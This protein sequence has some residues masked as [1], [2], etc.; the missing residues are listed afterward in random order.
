MNPQKIVQILKSND[1]FSSLGESHLATIV[2]KSIVEEHA[3]NIKLFSQGDEG[4]FAYLVLN[5]SVAVNVN[6]QDSVITVAIVTEGNLVGEIA[7][8]SS[9]PR[10]ASISTVT[11]TRL[12]RIEQATIRD[13]LD[14]SPDAAMSI[15]AELGIRIQCVNGAIATLTQAATALAADEFKP[16]MLDQLKAEA[17]RFSQFAEVFEHMAHEL[18]SK[19]QLQQEMQAATEIQRSFLPTG[20]SA[21]DHAT[22]FDVAA[23]MRPAKQ[24][25]GDFFDYF[26]IDE[27]HIGIAVGD[28]SGKGVPAAMFMS[29]SRTVL[30]TIARTDIDAGETLIRVND[31]LSEDNAEGMFVTIAY[32]KLDLRTGL[33]DY[34]C[35]GHEEA[36]IIGDN[37]FDKIEASGPVVGLFSGANYTSQ[38]RKLLPGEVVA[39]ATDGVTE[40]FSVEREMF[41][42]ERLEK[43]LIDNRKTP[44]D[45]II[46]TL[47][48][49]IDSFAKGCEQSDDITCL[50]MRYLG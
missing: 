20:I 3:E 16:T 4:D 27:H 37:G 46:T 10:T 18:T 19:N 14:S 39:F 50:A 31:L 2:E 41:G 49:E 21:G 47:F 28:V 43:S 30:K 44:V 7:A 25:G 1:S 6:A 35:A 42:F 15:I 8:F 33:F 22:A 9:T 5:G 32:G 38:Q 12:L 24:V 23:N 36:Y 34:V 45:D 48:G 29:V 26:M 40:A 11:E 17:N 13:I